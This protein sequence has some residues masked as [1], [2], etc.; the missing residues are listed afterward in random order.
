MIGFIFK[1]YYYNTFNQIG[2][3]YFR[4]IRDV[5][6]VDADGAGDQGTLPL[7]KFKPQIVPGPQIPIRFRVDGSQFTTPLI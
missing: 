3:I 4:E 6:K 2:L 5:L 7:P 1:V